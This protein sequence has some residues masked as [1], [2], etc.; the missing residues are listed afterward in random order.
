MLNNPIGYYITPTR[1]MAVVHVP[2]TPRSLS[3]FLRNLWKM[4][5]M[6]CLDREAAANV[7]CKLT[8]EVLE[9]SPAE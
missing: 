6:Q 8:Q 1:S 7:T 5:S 9:S 3:L 4:L 2:V